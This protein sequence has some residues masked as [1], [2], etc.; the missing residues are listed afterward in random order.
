MIKFIINISFF[1]LITL[2]FANNSNTLE[3]YHQ[4]SYPPNDTAYYCFI[5]DVFSEGGENYIKIRPF[6][7]LWGLNALIEAKKDGY[8][9]YQIDKVT[10]DTNWYVQSGNYI[11]DSNKTELKF[12]IDKKVKIHVCSYG[13]ILTISIEELFKNS[14]YSSEDFSHKYIYK[15]TETNEYIPFEIAIEKGKVTIIDQEWTPECTI[16]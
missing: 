7:Y 1:I 11:N 2:F 8:A 10:K 12:R 15:K 13:I 9:E 3:S 5:T 16:Y 14:F 6:Q 4:I